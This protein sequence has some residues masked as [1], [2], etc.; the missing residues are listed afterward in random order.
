M[1]V[2]DPRI[3]KSID[4]LS[5]TVQRQ[6]SSLAASLTELEDDL[7]NFVAPGARK[8]KDDLLSLQATLARAKRD[9]AV[10][11]ASTETQQLRLELN[12]ANQEVAR[13]AAQVKAV[14]L[15]L[16]ARQSVETELEAAESE[17]ERRARVHEA[18]LRSHRKAEREL[19]TSLAEAKDA[20]A[21]L[22]AVPP[23]SPN[24]LTP[25][26]MSAEARVQ[27]EELEESLAREKAR[28]DEQSER[29]GTLEKQAEAQRGLLARLEDEVDELRVEKRAWLAESS[30]M[31]EAA[32][33]EISRS[34]EL[35][36]KLAQ[37]RAERKRLEVE[38][39]SV[40][41]SLKASASQGPAEMPGSLVSMAAMA[42]R[43]DGT[44]DDDDD[45]DDDVRNAG[46]S[47]R[48]QIDLSDA[49]ADAALAEV[50]N[51]DDDD[52][53]SGRDSGMQLELRLV[54]SLAPGGTA[55]ILLFG[56][57]HGR[58]G[59]SIADDA[60]V[61]W[62][63]I[64]ADDTRG[65]SP[66]EQR[67][68]VAE[69]GGTYLCSAEDVGYRLLAAFAGREAVSKDIVTPHRP[70][71]TLLQTK[72]E[73]EGRFECV[74][75]DAAN[76]QQLNVVLTKKKIELIT[77]PAATAASSSR[78]SR[79]EPKPIVLQSEAWT[80]GISIRFYADDE[81]LAL[82]LQLGH[83]LKG[84]KRPPAL[85]LTVSS[86][87]QRDLVLLAI[88]AFYRPSWLASAVAG[89]PPEVSFL[90]LPSEAVLASSASGASLAPAPAAAMPEVSETPSDASSHST[91]S[92]AKGKRTGIGAVGRVLSFGRKK[93][94]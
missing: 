39:K 82:L 55:R 44:E 72:L 90:A 36:T 28:A 17:L 62:F 29:V 8:D 42:A 23:P 26:G 76:G 25:Q 27:L 35:R 41:A 50:D 3:M 85:T 58:G 10:H 6:R 81:G 56:G 2:A 46:G 86:R 14:E 21:A 4:R 34:G 75:A 88:A 53:D 77:V 48:T 15:M 40:S 9:E 18:A 91:T 84:S 80:K 7:K 31:E 66:P 16:K 45:D 65:T 57:E 20:L 93:K 60:N 69:V 79:S 74:A 78:R 24:R 22:R 70:M 94:P 83:G 43:A 61:S 19:A 11:D 63:R 89:T 47:V 37:E 71:L 33:L 52:S 49:A 32:G 59:A 13:M 54:G 1:T 38:L 73:Q 51:D 92:S 5:A 12:L 87:Q 64:R 68:L 30:R 67:L